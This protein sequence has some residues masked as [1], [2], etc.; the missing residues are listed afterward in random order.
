VPPDWYPQSYV[1]IGTALL[2]KARAMPES[3]PRTFLVNDAIGNYKQALAIDPEAPHA[4]NNIAVA[5]KMLPRIKKEPLQADYDEYLN[6]G[7]AFSQA[8][9]YDEAVEEFRRAVQ[10]APQSI[11]AHIY[12]GLGLL[13]AKHAPA[14]IAELRTAKAI[15]AAQ[16]NEFL[17]T[18]LH[19]PP[20][21]GNLDAFI[22]AQ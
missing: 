12:L 15:D 8:G 6:N 7:T 5:M 2:M 17:T 22:A 16:A 20:S 9:R 1:G 10:I 21:E 18:A 4:K 19:L 3:A 14:G 13:Q 11:E